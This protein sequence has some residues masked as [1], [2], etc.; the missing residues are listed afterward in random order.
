MLVAI[1]ARAADLTFGWDDLNGT[2]AQV[3]AYFV[4]SNRPPDTN[5][6]VVG[7]TLGTNAPPMRQL[8]I[9]N[10]TPGLINFHITA[11]NAW[12]ESLP[13]EILTLP[14]TNRAPTLIRVRVD[15]PMRYD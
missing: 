15:Y 1:W 8:T 9:T 12:G 11:S 7:F 2:N 10:V 5:W 6:T 14:P 4:K 3:R 13:S